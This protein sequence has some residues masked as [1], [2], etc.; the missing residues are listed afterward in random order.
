MVRTQIVSAT[1][2]LL[3][4]REEMG[5]HVK[6][7]ATRSP[8]DPGTFGRSRFSVMPRIRKPS[9][10]RFS[11]VLAAAIVLQSSALMVVLQGPAA[12]ATATSGHAA[13]VGAGL[14]ALG[15]LRKGSAV[16]QQP[17]TSG[18]TDIAPT[19]GISS[20]T[21]TTW[22]LRRSRSGGSS[23]TSTSTT[24]PEVTQNLQASLSGLT[25]VTSAQLTLGGKP[26]EVVGVNAYEIATDYGVNAGC[27][28]MV[29]DS[30]LDQFFA[31]LPPHSL[32]RFSAFQG[33]LATNVDT[34]QLDWAPLDRVFE[35]AAAYDQYLIPV[36][37]GQ[38]GYCDGQHWQDPSWYSGGFMQVFNSAVTSDG[39]GLTPISYWSYLQAIV[40]RYKNSPALGMWEPVSEADA[41]TCPIQNKGMN[42]NCPSEIVAANAL[43]HFFDVV[44]AEIHSL[45]PDHLVESGLEGGGQCG[46]AGKDFSFVSASPGIDVMSFH[47]YYGASDPLGGPPGQD[48]ATR[49]AQ[50]SSLE[51]PIIGGEIGLEA[52]S[53]TGCMTDAQRS[54]AVASV[55]QTLLAAGSSG[56]LWWDWVPSLSQPCNWDIAPGDP[57][58]S[59]LNSLADG[60]LPS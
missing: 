37:I 53:G 27:G 55:T 25:P 32:V 10:A 44:G 29:S 54:S 18:G 5:N 24:A 51:K 16:S 3:R 7:R 9:G 57:L 13:R 34:H 36:V 52:G 26:Y 50:A 35:A 12:S 56:L 38:G 33:G 60:L 8:V 59:T 28:P 19:S 42:C 15:A 22:S 45:D 21:T 48:V 30:Q 49:L 23:S 6:A 58:L 40:N 2:D 4:A 14:S 11:I 39:Q 31:S 43:R 46:T 1:D 20:T 41:E 17:G 47:D